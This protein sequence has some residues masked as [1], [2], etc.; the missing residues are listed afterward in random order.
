MGGESGGGEEKKKKKKEEERK[1]RER[2]GEEEKGVVRREPREEERR[3][4]KVVLTDEGRRIAAELFERVAAIN[5]NILAPLDASECVALDAMLGRL[6]AGADGAEP[7]PL[8][9]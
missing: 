3:E 2:K 1:E 7:A 9:R 8:M 5:R 6:Q 4:V